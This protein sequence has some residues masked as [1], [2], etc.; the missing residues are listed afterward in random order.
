MSTRPRA[1]THKSRTLTD[2][3]MSALP[4]E[5][6]IQASFRHVC[7]VPLADNTRTDCANRKTAQQA[8]FRKFHHALTKRP[9]A[10]LGVFGSSGGGSV[11]VRRF[12]PIESVV[13]ADQDSGRGRFGTEGTTGG[14]DSDERGD[15]IAIVRAEVHVVA[16]QK[17][18]NAGTCCP[19]CS[20]PGETAN[21]R[22]SVKALKLI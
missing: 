20:G 7:F 5:A 4:S 11:L 21:V 18:F 3:A 8:V 19:A 22:T 16:F 14:T 10:E 17:C 15:Y 1:C 9:R 13:H 12:S 6:D 2:L